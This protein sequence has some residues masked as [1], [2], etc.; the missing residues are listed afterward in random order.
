MRNRKLIIEIP[1]GGLGDHLFHS[2]LPRIAKETGE[3][4]KVFISKKSL[5]RH[6]DNMHIVWELNPY[7]D[8]F[9]DEKGITCNIMNITKKIAEKRLEN[10]LLD[11]IMLAYGLDD[12]KRSHEPENYYK[13]NYIP[14]YHKVIFDPNFLSWIGEIDKKDMMAYIK[15]KKIKFDAIMKI[16][17]NQA[18]YIPKPGDNFIETKTLTDFCNLIFS[19]KKL[20]CLTSGTATLAASLGKHAIV[21]FGEN[22]EYAYQHSKLHNYIKVE[23]CFQ[24][25]LK[26]FVKNN[27]F[28]LN[29]H[30]LIC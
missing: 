14:E 3:Y 16:R 27:I 19:C 5:F 18:L 26:S 13:P 30:K 1:Y 7:I 2:H 28:N 8:G 11:E 24:N 15:K 25:Q 23:K 29:K 21:F 10:N 6:S 9:T 4:D 12:G 17:T 20:Y 22:Q